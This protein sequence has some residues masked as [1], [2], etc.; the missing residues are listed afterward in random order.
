LAHRAL[1]QLDCSAI[2]TQVVPALGA[3]SQVRFDD[4]Y[5]R[6]R[7]L[8]IVIR[9]AVFDQVV[10]G[11]LQ[12]RHQFAS[13]DTRESSALDGWATMA[14]DAVGLAGVRETQAKS[15]EKQ[16]SSVQSR[17]TRIF[18]SSRGSLLK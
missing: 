4:L 9:A 18:F 16:M 6:G 13:Q 10:A 17:A 8:T 7:Q 5:L 15:L 11:E 2:R 1:R 3:A 14:I 12:Y